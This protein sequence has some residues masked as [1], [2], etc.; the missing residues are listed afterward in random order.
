[1]ASAHEAAGGHLG[2][3][4]L[5]AFPVTGSYWRSFWEKVFRIVKYFTFHDEEI[6]QYSQANTRTITE[7]QWQSIKCS[8]SINLMMK[9]VIGS[10]IKKT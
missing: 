1:M 5:G 4:K 8:L 6:K 10:F 9:T 7:E 3:K 2:D